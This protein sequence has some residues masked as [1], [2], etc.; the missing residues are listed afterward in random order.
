MNKF[1][2]YAVSSVDR[3][4]EGEKGTNH[5]E[6]NTFTVRQ[7]ARSIGER[8]GVRI[9][10]RVPKFRFKLS[11]ELRCSVGV[12]VRRWYVE[13]PWFSIR[14]HH[15]LHSDDDRAL[16]DHTWWFWTFVLR[17]GYVDRTLTG[18]EDMNAPKVAF[19]PAEH[20]HTV[21][22]NSGGCWTLLLTGPPVRKWGFWVG[23]KW[24]KSNKYFL[25]NGM[26]VCD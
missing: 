5:P 26:H 21:Q 18:D 1:T 6:I 4:S 10:H 22:V 9:L 19:R 12:Y 2:K 7:S 20:A 24:K 8:S 3:N 16:H 14:L 15:W 11:E 17:G 25:E 13:T 23:K